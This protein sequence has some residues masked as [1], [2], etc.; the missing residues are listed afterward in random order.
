MKIPIYE[1]QVGLTAETPEGMGPMAPIGPLRS[2][3]AAGL[4]GKVLE[5]AGTVLTQLSGEVI[6]HMRYA[7]QLNDLT[8]ANFTALDQL[9]VLQDSVKR[10]DPE[11][12]VEAFK[13]EAQNRFNDQYQNLPDPQVQAAF[14]N[15]W[16]AWYF[17]TLQKVSKRGLSAF[18]PRFLPFSMSRNTRRSN[19]S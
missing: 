4:P 18:R 19:G 3:E 10:C 11:V 16:T 5:Q 7:K 17:S 15:H 1:R 9:T 14:K 6:R 13:Q 2:M 8:N 12:Q